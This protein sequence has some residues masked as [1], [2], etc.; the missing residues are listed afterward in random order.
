M[1]AIKNYFNSLPGADKCIQGEGGVVY[2]GTFMG[3]ANKEMTR[4]TIG[5]LPYIR[6]VFIPL[7]EGME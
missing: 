2:L 7:F 3:T 5:Q 6:S 4:I 1:E